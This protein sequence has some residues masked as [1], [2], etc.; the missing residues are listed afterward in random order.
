MF[1]FDLKYQ[2]VDP[3]VTGVGIVFS[4][5]LTDVTFEGRRIS[6]PAA[7]FPLFFGTTLFSIVAP[8]VVISLENQ[9][10]TPQSFVSPF[11]VLNCSMAFTTVVYSL[12]S[13]FGYLKYGNE[14]KD[15]ITLNLPENEG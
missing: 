1:Q 6:G 3:F 7:E 4:Q 14:T 8:A 10:K 9:M 12:F 2:T 13:F 15:S 11:G 5:T